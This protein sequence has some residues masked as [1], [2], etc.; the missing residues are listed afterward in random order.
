MYLITVHYYLK[1]FHNI[2]LSIIWVSLL[3]LFRCSYVPIIENEKLKLFCITL[4]QCLNYFFFS[5]MSLDT[6]PG[7]CLFEHCNRNVGKIIN[8]TLA[9][10]LFCQKICADKNRKFLRELKLNSLEFETSVLFIQTSD[11]LRCLIYEIFGIN[12]FIKMSEWL[13]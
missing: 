11:L 4:L 10:F 7:Y 5:G 2:F 6:N 3:W 8:A 9:P 13:E 1:R 12:R